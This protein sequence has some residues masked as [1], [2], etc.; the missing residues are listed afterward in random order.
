MVP[1][2]YSAIPGINPQPEMPGDM[3]SQSQFPAQPVEPTNAV[4]GT[5]PLNMAQPV[6]DSQVQVPG[7]SVDPNAVLKDPNAPDDIKMLAFDHIKG[8]EAQEAQKVAAQQEQEIIEKQK[9]FESYQQQLAKAESFNAEASSRGLKPVALPKPE[10]FG[11]DAATITKLSN[12]AAQEAIAPLKQKAQEQDQMVQQAAQD[13][14]QQIH[15]QKKVE[16]KI[17]GQQSA[18][19]KAQDS[20]DRAMTDLN[21]QQAG[22]DNIDNDRFWKNQDTG[23]RIIAGIAMAIGGGDLKNN[24]AFQIIDKA[25]DRDLASQKLDQEKRLAIKT[26]ALKRAETEISRFTALSKDE[27]RKQAA[28]ALQLQVQ[29]AQ[30]ATQQEFLMRRQIAHA[31]TGSGGITPEQAYTIDPKGEMREN[32]IPL[33]NGNL[34]AATDKESAKKFKEWYTATNNAMGLVPVLK[35][36]VQDLSLLDKAAPFGL[37][38]DKNKIQATISDLVGQ[39]RLPFTGPGILS[40]TEYK[41]LVKDVIG[42]PTSL[43]SR[44]SVA[45]KQI[46]HLTFLLKNSQA[47]QYAAAGAKVD[48]QDPAQQKQLKLANFMKANK[49]LL[50]KDPEA[51][52]KAARKLNLV[53]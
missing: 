30:A 14:A 5:V 23:S 11:L 31:I 48:M 22:L 15:E 4:S 29:Q 12:P 26:N 47:A 50:M 2:D 27:E 13:Q 41:R 36:Q 6:G 45:L 9:G 52:E 37:S 3:S 7:K 39:L 38:S 17:I 16:N 20:M 35:Q 10:Q 43:M 19:V 51:L 18:L 42:D 46:D 8:Q 28:R 34:I 33:P 1:Q 49:D 25:I 53:D 32:L 21:N 24:P 40:D 44:K